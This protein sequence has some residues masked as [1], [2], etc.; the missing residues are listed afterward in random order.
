MTTLRDRL[1]WA[2]KRDVLREIR[3]AIKDE[4]AAV[5]M[6]SALANR[7]DKIGERRFAAK[8]RTIITEE[9]KHKS[10]LEK[11]L[12]DMKRWFALTIP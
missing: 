3:T 9:S 8:V 2:L 4:E 1:A 7:L 6:Y 12:K 5:I 10:D 11:L